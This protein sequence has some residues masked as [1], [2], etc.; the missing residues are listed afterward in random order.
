MMKP[1]CYSYIRFSTPDQLKGD[2]LR[3]QME[4]ADKWALEHGMVIDDNLRL[5]DLGLSAYHGTHKDKG[6]LGAFLELVKK[7]QISPGSVLLVESFDRLSREEVIDALEQFLSIIRQGIR[8]VTLSDGREY[9]KESITANYTDLIVSLTIMSRAHEESATKAYRGKAAWD[10]KRNNADKKKL[11]ARAPAWLKLSAD[12]TTF[13]VFP[14]RAATIERIFRMKLDGQGGDTIARTLNAEGIKW[15]Q[16]HGH[17]RV[18][19]NGW[20]K[21]YVD[22]IL[23]GRAVLGEYQPMTGRGEKRQP[24]GD[25][26]ANY[27]PRII[28]DELFYAVQQQMARNRGKGGRNGELQNLFG[29]IC[30]CGYC[31]GKMQRINKGS[32]TKGGQFLICDN[33]RRGLGCER[34]PVSYQTFEKLILTYA[35]GLSLADLLPDAKEARREQD[36]ARECLAAIQAERDSKESKITNLVTAIESLEDQRAVERLKSRITELMD[37]VEELSGREQEAQRELTRLVSA[38]ETTQEHLESVNELYAALARKDSPELRLKLRHRLRQL[39]DD[40]NIY[41]VGRF[42]MT[43]AKVE[44][45]L[46]AVF[47]VWPEYAGTKELD[48]LRAE[49][50][51][52]IN[53]KNLA[54]CTVHFNGGSFRTLNLAGKQPTLVLDFDREGRKFCN[55]FLDSEGKV[56]EFRVVNGKS[57]LK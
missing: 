43:P 28:P 24:A 29:A 22:K 37:S 26:I 7:G 8:V 20:R 14:E 45:Q 51:G 46:S 33:A 40:I 34:H 57:E 6:A 21:S 41:P 30:R 39:I 52:Q 12:K 55:K 49:L 27:F 32:G 31:G 48:Q 53:N 16:G 3:R 5:R 19:E 1:K 23:R 44:A 4:A 35:K 36:K 17:G 2:S 15:S 42:L 13:E 18:L 11:T 38:G 25:P 9:S 50:T 47:D 10:K 56:K 54:R